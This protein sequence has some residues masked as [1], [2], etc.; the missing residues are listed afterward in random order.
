[1]SLRHLVQA[2]R[3]AT[4]HG[5]TD[6]E[7]CQRSTGF[8]K[9]YKDISRCSRVVSQKCTASISSNGCASKACQVDFDILGL[10]RAR[11]DDRCGGSQ[12][13]LCA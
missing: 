5:K 12:A 1:M 2:L 7:G 4:C 10:V 11:V 13:L 8:L 9:A 3:S 6:Q